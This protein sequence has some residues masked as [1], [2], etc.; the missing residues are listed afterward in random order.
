MKIALL[1]DSHFG[2]RNDSAPM[3][4]SMAQFYSRVFFPTLD[5][6]DIKTV[7]HLGDYFDRRKY[8]NI[9]TGA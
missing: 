6:W 1:A 7:I 2:A 4:Q 8:T 3:Q 5:Q 9:V